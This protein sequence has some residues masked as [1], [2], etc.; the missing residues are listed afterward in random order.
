MTPPQVSTISGKS[1]DEL[2]F[3]LPSV[4]TPAAVVAGPSVAVQL[5]A[6]V[7]GGGGG[8]QWNPHRLPVLQ[9]PAPAVLQTGRPGGQAA[10]L[11]VGN[12]QRQHTRPVPGGEMVVG[13]TLT[14]LKMMITMRY[15]RK[16]LV[17]VIIMRRGGC[18]G[19]GR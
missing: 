19:G 8:L 18:G 16:V 13:M 4:S 1:K 7:A 11:H 15:R 14:M 3:C 2:C 6:A 5:V 17:M 9:H 12:L 10:R